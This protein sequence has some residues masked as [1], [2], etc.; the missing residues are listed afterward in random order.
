M[1]QYLND[2]NESHHMA[3]FNKEIPFFSPKDK[4]KKTNHR[5]KHGVPKYC[6]TF[7]VKNKKTIENIKRNWS[8][9][10]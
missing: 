10:D 2:A 1:A 5:W 9:P 7:F 6:L 8:Q 3:R 4:E